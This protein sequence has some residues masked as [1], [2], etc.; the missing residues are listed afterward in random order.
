MKCGSERELKHLWEVEAEDANGNIHLQLYCDD[1]IE[2]A[3]DEYYDLFGTAGHLFRWIKVGNAEDRR[4]VRHNQE[5]MAAH[6][7]N[8][9]KRSKV[10]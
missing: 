9:G 2:R 7:A 6:I 10:F 8:N 1:C 4:I 3:L 5:L